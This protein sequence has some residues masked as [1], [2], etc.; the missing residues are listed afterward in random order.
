VG[1]IIYLSVKLRW[2]MV[3]VFWMDN[4]CSASILPMKTP[5]LSCAGVFLLQK[6]IFSIAL[7][8]IT[9]IY[10]CRN[11]VGPVNLVSPLDHGW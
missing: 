7:A 9:V 3:R 5:V 11:V 4:A 2:H 10:G 6:R 1:Y 8:K